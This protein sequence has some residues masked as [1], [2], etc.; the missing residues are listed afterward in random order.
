MIRLGSAEK[1]DEALVCKEPAD[2]GDAEAQYKLGMMVME[3]GSSF[4]WEARTWLARAAEQGVAD[5]TLR[6]KEIN[7]KERA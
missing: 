6:L 3:T 4:K 7:G 1:Y 2:K 5:A